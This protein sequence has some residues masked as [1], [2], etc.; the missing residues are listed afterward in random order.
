MSDN[1]SRTARPQR[2]QRGRAQREEEKEEKGRREGGREEETQA[3]TAKESTKRGK[4]RTKLKN[5][6]KGEK[7]QMKDNFFTIKFEDVT[8]WISQQH[9]KIA[10]PYRL[11]GDI[12]YHAHLAIAEEIPYTGAE[13]DETAIEAWDTQCLKTLDSS[14][15]TA[16]LMILPYRRKPLAS[17]R[18]TVDTPDGRH[19]ERKIFCTVE[20]DTIEAILDQFFH[21]GA[22]GLS[23][24]FREYCSKTYGEYREHKA[25]SNRRQ[26]A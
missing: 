6:T 11:T 16:A 8:G 21:M 4:I 10:L 24:S 12:L 18:L 9:D 19:M 20:L 17:I 7:Q 2:A 1:R 13:D 26:I 22:S 25:G 14:N 3:Q 5:S 15:V 23:N